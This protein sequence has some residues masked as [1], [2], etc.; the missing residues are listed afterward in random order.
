MRRVTASGKVDKKWKTEEVIEALRQTGGSIRE[1]CRMLDMAT[2][3]FFRH[4]RYAPEVEAE[5]DVLWKIGVHNV[6]DTVYSR[7]LDGDLKAC[8]LYLKYSPYAKELGWMPEE[9]VTV[10]SEKPL[11][12]DEK[13]ALKDQ[14]FG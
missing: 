7:A 10:A 11:T 6:V 12:E 13:N 9:K 5:L 8:N 3:T 1:A 4:W 14:L 2:T